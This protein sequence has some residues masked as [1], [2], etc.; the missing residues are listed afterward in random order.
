M[1]MTGLLITIHFYFMFDYYFFFPMCPVTIFLKQSMLT[2]L[3][4][5]E[6]NKPSRHPLYPTKAP[7]LNVG[8]AFVSI[9]HHFHFPSRLACSR[10]KVWCQD[11]CWLKQG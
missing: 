9:C 1:N 5:S 11:F 6:L 8:A 4:R 10:E 2:F 7:L 3:T